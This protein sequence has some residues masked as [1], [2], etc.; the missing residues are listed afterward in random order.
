MAEPL[1]LVQQKINCLG[2]IRGINYAQA[3]IGR[4][5]TTGSL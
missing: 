4:G 5:L 2:D 3:N 1:D